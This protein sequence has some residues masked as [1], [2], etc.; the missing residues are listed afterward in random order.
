MTVK[1]IAKNP[2]KD[3]VISGNIYTGKNGSLT[4]TS[5]VKTD[6]Q[7]KAVIYLPAGKQKIK[8]SSPGYANVWKQLNV[9]D[10]GSG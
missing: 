4:H 6:S 10:A 7:G 8:I 5:E 3:V 9:G 2:M 1:D